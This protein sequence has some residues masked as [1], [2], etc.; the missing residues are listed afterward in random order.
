MS[1]AIDCQVNARGQQQ[2][3]RYDDAVRPKGRG[4]CNSSLTLQSLTDS[5]S[6]RHTSSSKDGQFVSARGNVSHAGSFT[7]RGVWS[8]GTPEAG[9]YLR[10]GESPDKPDGP[11][12]FAHLRRRSPSRVADGLQP[13]SSRTRDGCSVTEVLRAGIS[14]P[15]HLSS[16]GLTRRS[17]NHR[18]LALTSAGLLDARFRG[19]DKLRSPQSGAE[20]GGGGDGREH[21]RGK[22]QGAQHEE[23]RPG[24][25]R[26]G[27]RG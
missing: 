4:E 3:R 24:R 18:A 16:P 1:S 20:G 17:S 19:H 13:A 7:R 22:T 14:P 8:L 10:A 5:N 15:L 26:P 25:G 9:R 23:G 2:G 21:D 27:D 12:S 6:E 11:R